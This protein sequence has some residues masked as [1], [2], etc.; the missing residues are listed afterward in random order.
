M[1]VLV[2]VDHPQDAAAWLDWAGPGGGAGLQPGHPRAQ[3][4]LH[5]PHMRGL[6]LQGLCAPSCNG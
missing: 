1:E 5:V 2:N 3:V 6:A 4:G